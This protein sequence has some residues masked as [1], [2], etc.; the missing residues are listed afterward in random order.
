[1]KGKWA[2]LKGWWRWCGTSSPTQPGGGAGASW[3]L[4]GLSSLGFI[5]LSVFIISLGEGKGTTQEQKVLEI[6]EGE[7]SQQ[8]SLHHRPCTQLAMEDI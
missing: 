1:M 8:P 6:C 2:T 3:G 4:A 5:S 7:R